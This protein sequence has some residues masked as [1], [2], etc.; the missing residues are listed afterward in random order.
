MTFKFMPDEPRD[1]H[2]RP[3]LISGPDSEFF[4]HKVFLIPSE[5]SPIEII[6]QINYQVSCS[7]FQEALQVNNLLAVGHEKHFYLFDI[8]TK[9][10]L[11][12]LEM[13]GYFGHLNYDQPYF[14]VSDAIGLHCITDIGKTRW[15]KRNLAIDGVIITNFTADEIHGSGE[16]DPPGGWEDFI[17]DKAT[18]IRLK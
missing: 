7:P 9:T 10:N 2:T 8:S 6:F 4:P 3:I 5:S 18:G 1:G 13:N 12:R 14:F 11:L 16:L 17:L 15:S